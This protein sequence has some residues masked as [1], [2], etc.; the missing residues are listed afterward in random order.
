M[1]M[2]GRG[3]AGEEAAEPPLFRCCA[4]GELAAEPGSVTVLGGDKGDTPAIFSVKLIAPDPAFSEDE[5]HDPNNV[6]CCSSLFLVS[7][8]YPSPKD[9]TPRLP[10]S[11]PFTVPIAAKFDYF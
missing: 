5:F 7:F 11:A 10:S 3:L 1:L 8:L 6:A 2:P 9:P 4:T